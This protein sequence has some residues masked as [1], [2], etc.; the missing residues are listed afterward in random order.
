MGI[1]LRLPQYSRARSVYTVV[2]TTLTPC[3][4][5]T[6]RNEGLSEVIPRERDRL[7]G[8]IRR[9]VPNRRDAEDILQDFF[10]EFARACGM[11]QAEVLGLQWEDVNLVCATADIR[12]TQRRGAFSKPKS[13]ASRR[14]IELPAP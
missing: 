11:R 5:M 4:P 1:F 6:E 2:D 8:F 7:Y 3:I 14:T 13:K 12:R 10:F 9:R